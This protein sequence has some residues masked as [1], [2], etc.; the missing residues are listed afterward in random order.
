MPTWDFPALPK[1][2]TSACAEN[3]GDRVQSWAR[4]GNYLRVRGEYANWGKKPR[5]RMELP[6]RARRILLAHNQRTLPVGTTSA[7][8]ENTL[9][10]I[11]HRGRAWNYLRVRGEYRA[12]DTPLKAW[13]ELPPRARRIRHGDFGR[14]QG[15]GT[16]SACAE[17]TFEACIRR[18]LGGNYLRVRGE[19]NSGPDRLFLNKEL[20]PR[21][22]RILADAAVV[23]AHDGT[24]SACAENTPGC[25]AALGKARNYLRVRGEYANSRHS[26]DTTQEL[27]PRTR[28]IPGA[29]FDCVAA[30]GTTSAHAENT[31]GLLRRRRGD[32]NY[33]R[34]RGEYTRR[35]VLVKL[36]RELPPRTRRIP[37]A[38]GVIGVLGGTTSAHAENTC[39]KCRA[40]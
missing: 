11:S 34:A 22:R 9:L 18:R 39:S 38:S 30:P 6:P 5:P 33:L 24:T 7:C 1:G 16:T 10:S 37:A 12:T 35:V 15:I 29:G 19:Y 8:A 31:W 36:S 14:I 2:T 17:N 13:G 40:G 25:L 32:R 21:A 4:A 23:T 27:P 26:P 20:P 28:R 3:T